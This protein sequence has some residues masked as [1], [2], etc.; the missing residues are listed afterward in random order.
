MLI[1]RKIIVAPNIYV[2]IYRYKEEYYF[3][4]RILASFDNS[5]KMEEIKKKK[6]ID[7]ALFLKKEKRLQFPFK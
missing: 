6:M 2:Y 4:Q 1:Y 3:L 5:A 7:I